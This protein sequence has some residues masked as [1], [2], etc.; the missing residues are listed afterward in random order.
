MKQAINKING[1][2][3]IEISGGVTYERLGEISKI[4][5]DFIG[6]YFFGPGPGPN[7]P[8]GRPGGGA[9]RTPR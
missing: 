2:A 9:P 7:A 4:G 6:P 3:K 1:K 5:A 8:C